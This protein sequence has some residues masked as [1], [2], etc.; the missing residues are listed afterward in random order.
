MMK[1]IRQAPFLRVLLPC[2]LGIGGYGMCEISLPVWWLI[3]PLLT[4]LIWLLYPFLPLNWRLKFPLFPDI[5]TQLF[6]VQAG[7]L[8]SAGHD[9][10]QRAKHYSHF[11]S[12]DQAY[13]VRVLEAPIRKLKSLCLEIELVCAID[14]LNQEHYRE[15]HALIYLHPDAQSGTIRRGDRLL[16]NNQWQSIRHGNNPGSFNYPAYLRN[17]QIYHRA[18]YRQSGWKKIAGREHYWSDWIQELSENIRQQLRKRIPD[19]SAFGLA[20]AL[21]IGYRRNIDAEQMQVYSKVGL[22]HLIAISGMHMALIY[23]G[24]LFLLAR[25]PGLKNKINIQV[26]LAL[27]GMWFFALLTGLPPSVLRAAVMFTFVGWAKLEGNHLFT[28]NSVLGSACVLLW[29]QPNWLYDIG[30]QLSYLAVLSLILFYPLINL[31]LVGLPVWCKP[32]TDLMACTLA[33]QVLTL[34]AC[35]FYFH[36]FPLVF[37]LSN[38]VAVP[39]TTGIL[40]LEIIL[41]IL[42]GFDFAAKAL[43]AVIQFIIQVLNRFV[44]WLAEFE[45]LISEGWWL[46]AWQVILAYFFIATFFWGITQGKRKL[47]FVSGFCALFFLG[48]S[49][50]QKWTAL[51]QNKLLFLDQPGRPSLC[52]LSGPTIWKEDTLPADFK[53]AAY[54]QNPL[55][56]S[57]AIRE[58]RPLVWTKWMGMQWLEWSGLR[59]AVLSDQKYIP[60]RPLRSTILLL[61]NLTW[62]D[63]PLLKKQVLPHCVIL[64]SRLPARKSEQWE[65]LLTQAGFRVWNVHR[66]GALVMN[67]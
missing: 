41:V 24:L 9:H 22:A 32:I 44:Q 37:L 49:V 5:L 23:S 33:A 57:L 52:V 58:S 60:T 51:H 40:Y 45:T 15:G 42:C 39:L 31:K 43:G 17:K 56:G 4:G 36:Q 30:F 50:R 53:Y 18:F 19:P 55:Y 63:I 61:E 62:L 66:Q 8:I 20:E 27:F 26:I 38:L 2:A 7:F 64:D 1:F 6:I 48:I 29:I 65:R 28:I 34:P 16:I 25:I 14:T 21:L 67:L 46:T 59:L 10:L 12:S 13:V 11:I 54:V 47:V 35:L 3:V